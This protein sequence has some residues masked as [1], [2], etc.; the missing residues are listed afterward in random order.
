MTTIVPTRDGLLGLAIDPGVYSPEEVFALAQR[1]CEAAYRLQ[2]GPTDDPE[3][4]EKQQLARERRK[5]SA[6]EE[7]YCAIHDVA[8]DHNRETI[9]R[10]EKLEPGAWTPDYLDEA[11]AVEGTLR[12]TFRTV[13]DWD[14]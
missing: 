7:L 9:R 13:R 12:Q 11:Q 10:R 6:F 2:G 1:L 5:A 3:V 14:Y 8:S 4:R